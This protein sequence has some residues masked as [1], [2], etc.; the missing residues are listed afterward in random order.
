MAVQGRVQ[1]GSYEK[2]G[3]RVYTTDVVAERVQFLEWGD[4]ENKPAAQGT[5][6]DMTDIEGFYQIDNEDIPF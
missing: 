6:Q 1:T 3:K 4:K 5:Q 2:D